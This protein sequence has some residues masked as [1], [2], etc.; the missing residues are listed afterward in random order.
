MVASFPFALDGLA[1]CSVLALASG[2][3][4]AAASLIKGS[5]VVGW[6]G[7][8]SQISSDSPFQALAHNSPY[9]NLPRTAF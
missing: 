9:L 2:E 7:L 6:D 1:I 5:P 3:D 8:P 4:A